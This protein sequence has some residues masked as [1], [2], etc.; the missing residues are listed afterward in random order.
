MN[1]ERQN[2]TANGHATTY[3]LLRRD[4]EVHIALEGSDGKTYRLEDYRGEKAVVLAWF[5][6]AFTGG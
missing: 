4:H 2:S 3:K 5:P 6:K 1:P